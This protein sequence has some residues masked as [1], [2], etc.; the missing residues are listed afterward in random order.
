MLREY[1]SKFSDLMVSCLEIE[2][3]LNK[4][5]END[6]RFWVGIALAKKSSFVAMIAQ[7]LSMSL[8]LDAARILAIRIRDELTIYDEESEYVAVTQLQLLRYITELRSRVEDQLRGK[9]FYFVNPEK[10]GYY[11][12][13]N[14][15]G[16]NVFNNFPSTIAD[17]EDAGKCLALGLG[18]SAVMHLMRVLESGLKGLAKTRH[19]NIPYAPS[20]ESY[21]NQIQNQIAENHKKKS[22]DWLAV[23]KFYRDVSG[24]LITIKQA[25]R[26]P[27]MHIE[28]RYNI[29]EAEEI[30]NT[31]KSF[32]Q[33]FSSKFDE[34]G[35]DC[36]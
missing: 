4:L 27:T 32:M 16:E 7:E 10:A 19:I 13:K 15:F 21:L 30:F 36:P 35:K 34:S 6:L 1:S 14:L 28:R 5:G 11:K 33:L 31:V 18:T 26:N 24:D 25:W 23:E 17:I 22:P 29:E 8:E 20:W 2:N 3:E 9:L 12:T